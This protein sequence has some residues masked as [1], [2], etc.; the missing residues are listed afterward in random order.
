MLP[1]NTTCLW[2][3]GLRLRLRGRKWLCEEL[4]GEGNIVC[5]DGMAG[6]SSAVLRMQGAQDAF[7]EYPGINVI[8]S[9]YADWDYA[10]AKPVME[11]LLAAYDDI[12]GIGLR[13]VI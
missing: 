7:A 11:N 4:G 9:E 6:L 1:I 10:T 13:A 8:A 12:D 3:P 5:L 2:W